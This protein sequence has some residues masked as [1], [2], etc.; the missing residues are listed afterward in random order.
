MFCCSGKVRRALSKLI[1][2]FLE[3]KNEWLIAFSAYTNASKIMKCSEVK[4]SSEISCLHGI[5]SLSMMWVLTS[6]VYELYYGHAL[7]NA[8]YI[9]EVFQRFDVMIEALSNLLDY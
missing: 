6:H 1:F 9:F 2:D 5:R 8:N 3:P 4:S 7:A